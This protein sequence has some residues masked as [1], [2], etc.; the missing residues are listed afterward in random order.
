MSW[1]TRRAKKE[2]RKKRRKSD[3][4][5]KRTCFGNKRSLESKEGTKKR[6]VGKRDV[7]RTHHSFG[8]RY[9]RDDE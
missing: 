2:K 3:E 8:D 5:G 6:G 4:A 7:S 9:P 1:S